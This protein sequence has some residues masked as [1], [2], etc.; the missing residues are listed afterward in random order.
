MKLKNN[1][2]V[3]VRAPTLSVENRKRLVTFVILLSN[4]NKQVKATKAPTH[5]SPQNKKAREEQARKIKPLKRPVNKYA[6]PF[7]FIT[8]GVKPQVHWHTQ[9]TNQS[10]YL[11]QHSPWTP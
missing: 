2:N 6:G 5:K 9:N 11:Q 4:I 8:N 1:V 3:V 10:Q 7:I